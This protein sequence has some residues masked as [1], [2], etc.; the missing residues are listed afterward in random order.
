MYI[1]IHIWIFTKTAQIKLVEKWGQNWKWNWRSNKKSEKLS[2]KLRG[3]LTDLTCIFGPNLEI[4]TSIRGDSLHQTQN[5]IS[6]HFQVQFNLESK[7]QPAPKT[8]GILTTV[9]CISGDARL[10]GAQRNSGLTHTHTWTDTH[11]H[12]HTHTH[13]RRQWQYPKAKTGIG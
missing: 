10:N 2:P 7:G 4:L 13:R 9:F 3:V 12:T 1:Y 6:F 8:S 11:T 5:G